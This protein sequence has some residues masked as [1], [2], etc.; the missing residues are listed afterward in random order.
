[1][2][3][4]YTLLAFVTMLTGCAPIHPGGTTIPKAL[5]GLQSDIALSG[6]MSLSGS[7]NWTPTETKAFTTSV[8]ASQCQQHRADPIVVSMIGDMAMTLTGTYSTSG[9]FTVGSMTTTPSLGFTG[10]ASRTLGQQIQLPVTYVA[11][12]A[13]PDTVLVKKL[14]LIRTT[15]NDHP[16]LSPERMDALVKSYWAE[17]DDLQGRINVMISSWSLVACGNAAPDVLFG[18]HR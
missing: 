10:A 2:R 4:V 6:A 15:M 7:K 14:A 16:T 13:L 5:A 3:I 17:R 11:L 8:Q 12:S 1:M 9:Q 18:V